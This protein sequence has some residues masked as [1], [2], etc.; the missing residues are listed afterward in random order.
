MLGSVILTLLAAYH[1]SCI[2]MLRVA[3]VQYSLSLLLCADE[4]CFTDNI[5]K[6]PKHFQ[7]A[8]AD[9]LPYRS[10]G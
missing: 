2:G 4:P 10:L 7:T 3:F 1:D 8:K 6:F 9:V 5:S